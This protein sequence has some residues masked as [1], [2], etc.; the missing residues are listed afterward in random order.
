MI[1]DDDCGGID[2]M[3]TWQVK[4]KYSKKIYPGAALSTTDPT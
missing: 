4:P 2:G 1:E 3:S